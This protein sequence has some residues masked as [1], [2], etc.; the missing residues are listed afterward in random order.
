[1]SDSFPAADGGGPPGPV[2]RDGLAL[3]IAVRVAGRTRERGARRT[4]TAATAC[5]PRPDGDDPI[6][7]SSRDR[8]ASSESRGSRMSL[9]HIPDEELVRR[10][11]Q[12][13]KG[14][15]SELFERHAGRLARLGRRHLVGAL[16]RRKGESDLVQ[17]TLLAAF[18][19]L[20]RFEAAGP[21]SFGR[22]LD[23]ILEHK[24]RDFARRELRARRAVTREEG[25][26]SGVRPVDAGPSP[27]SVAG[28]GER[29]ARLKSAIARLEGDQRTVVVLVHQRG[30]TFVEA[31]RL[32]GRS[33]DAARML[34]ARAVTRLAT[35]M[36]RG[37][38][39]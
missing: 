4:E 14:A 30:M 15:A 12:G 10:S 26:L 27:S 28:R 25:G 2:E 32:M 1:M 21:G 24:A 39:A 18:C 35:E 19:D 17:D 7:Q 34:Y 29:A 38:S 13:E 23:A 9:E 33:A 6:E 36:R 20:E 22:W 37:G 8:Y 11:L 3:L 31:G 16:K 5:G